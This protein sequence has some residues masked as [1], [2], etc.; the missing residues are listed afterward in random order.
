L[1]DGWSSPAGSMALTVK[2]I[3]QLILK[4]FAWLALLFWQ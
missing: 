3:Y 1:C 2:L 4:I